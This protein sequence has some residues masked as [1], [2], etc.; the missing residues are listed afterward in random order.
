[1]LVNAAQHGFRKLCSCKSALLRIS[2]TLFASRI[3]GL[4][5][6]VVTIDYNKAFDTLDYDFI[7][8]AAHHCGLNEMKINWLR[9]YHSGRSQSVKYEGVLSSPAALTHGVPQ[10]SVLGPIILNIFINGLLNSL[11][12]NSS[13]AFAD[14]VTLI[15]QG[16]NAIS[17][18]N[19]IQMFLNTLCSWS[20]DNKLSI[21]TA[22]C[23]SMIICSKIAKYKKPFSLLFQLGSDNII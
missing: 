1:M 4:W 5:T 15:S 22:L 3:A 18:S 13:I 16:D 20:L 12:N 6:C 19:N 23:F 9:S 17:A 2:K 14:D 7:L 8:Y 11:S 21:N 10:S